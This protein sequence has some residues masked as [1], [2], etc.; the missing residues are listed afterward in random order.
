M[1]LY[2]LFAKIYRILFDEEA[3][4]LSPE[5][6]RT[7][8]EYGDLYMTL[9]GVYIRISVSTKAPHCLPHFVLDTLLL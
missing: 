9:D 2:D 8:K 5:G 6:Q 3:P 1:N 7:I 4:C